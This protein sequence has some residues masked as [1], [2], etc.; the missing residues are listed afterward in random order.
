MALPLRTV[1]KLQKSEKIGF[2]KRPTIF[3]SPVKAEKCLQLPL[4]SLSWFATS[5]DHVGMAQ[6]W[7]TNGPTRTVICGLKASILTHFG[8]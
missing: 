2:G 3:S 8:G 1:R 5:C 7:G 6:D 4:F